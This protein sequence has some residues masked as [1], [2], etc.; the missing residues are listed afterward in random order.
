MLC[1]TNLDWY[2]CNAVT[3]PLNV[4]ATFVKFAMP[5]PMMSTCKHKHYFC[6]KVKVTLYINKRYFKFVCEFFTK[7]IL[8]NF[9]KLDPSCGPVVHGA[10]GCRQKN[11]KL[12]WRCHQLLSGFLAKGH[13]PRVLQESCRSLMIRVLMKWSWGLCTDLWPFPPNEV[14]RIAQHVRKG[15]GRNQ[16]KDGVGSF[17]WSQ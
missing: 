9:R 11:L 14:G 7:N 5:P 17:S 6:I 4:A 1:S 3:I 8:I 13:L 2:S 12:V 15:E 16:G 10:M